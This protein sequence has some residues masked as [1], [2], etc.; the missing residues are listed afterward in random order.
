[1]KNI[2]IIQARYGSQRF[3]K[4]VIQK[5]WND[6][7]ALEVLVDRLRLSSQLDMIVVATTNE[8]ED[9]Q[10]VELCKRIGIECINKGNKDSAL[11]SVIQAGNY[12]LD[13]I[14][15]GDFNLID[16]TAD[17]PFIDPFQLDEIIKE[18]NK[19]SYDGYFSNCMIRSFPIGFD[20]QIYTFSLLKKI[21]KIVV[22]KNHRVHCGWNILTYSNKLQ[23]FHFTI[24]GNI[25]AEEK[26]FKPDWRIVIDY[27]EDLILLKNIINYFNRIDFTY[28]EV[29]EYLIDNPGLLKINGNCIQKIAGKDL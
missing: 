28:Q 25:V 21:N 27:K 9:L 4:K 7:T 1:M 14:E 16:I 26:Y 17:C 8:P 10:L 18:K 15:K 12:V 13:L 29:I 11:D 6:K 22:N 19:S 20:I 3:P 2:A 23:D 5:L 24:F